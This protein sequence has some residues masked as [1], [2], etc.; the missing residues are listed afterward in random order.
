MS[1]E[2]MQRCTLPVVFAIVAIG[3]SLH[4]GTAIQQKAH[5]L[6]VSSAQAAVASEPADVEFFNAHEVMA[7]VEL[8]WMATS[9]KDIDGFRIYRRKS[10]QP[11][12]LMV[13]TDGLISAWRFEYVDG[14]PER[15]QKYL[16]VL[17]VVHAD[18]SEQFS[19]PVEVTTTANAIN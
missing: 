11:F 1:T 15:G 6:V 14:G 13:N 7:G 19:Q 12:Y 3:I 2:T 16:Y 17:G 10:S 18:G 8:T 5:R 9:E 4:P